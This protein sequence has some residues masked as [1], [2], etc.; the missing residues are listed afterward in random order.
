MK[1]LKHYTFDSDGMSKDFESLKQLKRE[2]QFEKALKLIDYIEKHYKRMYYD[3][4]VNRVVLNKDRAIIYR[5]MKMPEK[6]HYY[7][8]LK[9]LYSILNYC[10][11]SVDINYYFSDQFIDYFNVSEQKAIKSYID[12]FKPIGTELI[13][14]IKNVKK[15]I[16]QNFL[17]YKYVDSSDLEIYFC[18]LNKRLNELFDLIDS[19]PIENYILS[20]ETKPKEQF[21]SRVLRSFHS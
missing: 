5:K 9:E 8:I 6:G 14:E 21:L 1:T 19:N 3:K 18:S 10:V 20:A 4:Y 15:S 13:Q 16:D 7:D 17:Y 12:W 11:R 2:K